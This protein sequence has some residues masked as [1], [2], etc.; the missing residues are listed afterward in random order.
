MRITRIQSNEMT[1]GYNPEVNAN[2]IHHLEK[3]KKNKA[4]CEFLN[5][6]CRITNDAEKALR[7]A[8]T[9]GKPVLVSLLV[10][11][12]VPAK[13]LLTNMI[14]SLF[15]QFGYRTKEIES[16]KEEIK[17]LNLEEEYP[18]HWLNML[19]NTLQQHE[20]SDKAE[21]MA[22]ELA[23][24][25]HK[26]FPELNL[27]FNIGGLTAAIDK[28]NNEE[29]DDDS[30]EKSDLEESIANGRSKVEHY[31]PTG[32]ALK[33]FDGLG[34]MQ[35]LKKIL[36]SMVVD[37]LK[38]PKEVGLLSKA[39]G[40]KLP[41]AILLYGPPGCGK[42]TIVEHMSVE[43]DTQLLKVKPGR[44]GSI[45]IN[46]TEKNLE[47]VFDYAAS[48][49]TEEKPVILF[50][51]DVDTV[52]GSRDSNGS[53]H[54]EEELGTFLDRIQNA[55][56]D[57]VLV[58]AATNKY[59]K[60]DA[61]VKRRFTE[62]VFVGLPD[63]E[64]RESIIRHY[65]S[66]DQCEQANTLLNDDAAIKRLAEKMN[67]FPNSLIRTTM[68]KAKNIPFQEAKDMFIND[69]D[70]QMR[71]VTENDINSIIDLPEIQNQ[72]IKESNYQSNANR[73]KIGFG[74]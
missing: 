17:E 27:Q 34:G 50:I 31:M 22:N 25:I 2:L 40:V 16:Y 30:E 54:K 42:T 73:K 24:E 41:D 5:K 62:Q 58:I 74:G 66:G 63:L 60:I 10:G 67:E 70:I 39:Y 13:I 52:I 32:E 59:D 14:D 72:K 11:A 37:F 1:F 18:G 26:K 61:A 71:E 46:G 38:H 28:S 35:N 7:E 55:H 45:Y 21:D 47:A 64:S 4:Y 49:A 8:E 6:W 23:A 20:N 48:I 53:A 56:N 36:N 69:G 19:T 57:N 44:Y 29:I 51:D 68:L 33:G 65:L 3:S 15:P 9:K 43:A 12:F